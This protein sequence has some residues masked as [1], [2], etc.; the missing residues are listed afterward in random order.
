MNENISGNKRKKFHDIFPRY[1]YIQI[2]TIIIMVVGENEDTKLGSI[3]RPT[4]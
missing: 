1:V 4:L 3:N 2:M